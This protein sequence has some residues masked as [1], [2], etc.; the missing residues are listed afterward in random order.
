[1]SKEVHDGAAR[2]YCRPLFLQAFALKIGAA[3]YLTMKF[4]FENKSNLETAA[5]ISYLKV[6]ARK[7]KRE[8]SCSE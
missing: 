3:L 7:S 5:K 8:I 2:G 6:R 1:M 4:K